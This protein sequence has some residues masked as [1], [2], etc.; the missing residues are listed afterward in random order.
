MD[1]LAGHDTD[2]QVGRQTG[3]Q[4]AREADRQQLPVSWLL[5]WAAS[6]CQRFETR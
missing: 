6:G 4:A 1:E 5:V 3:R 2:R